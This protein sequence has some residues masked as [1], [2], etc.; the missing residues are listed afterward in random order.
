MTAR[1]LAALHALLHRAT[2]VLAD[3]TRAD[4]A[5]AR[6]VVAELAGRRDAMSERERE[7]LELNADLP[8][9]AFHLDEELRAGDPATTPRALEF[10]RRHVTRLLAEYR[11]RAH[12][13]VDPLD[14]E[15]LLGLARLTRTTYEQRFAERYAAAGYRRPFVDK[16]YRDYA[17]AGLPDSLLLTLAELAVAGEH[18]VVLCVLKGAL[19]YVLLMELCGLAPERV[20]YVMCGRSTGSHIAPE[21]MVAP[22]GFELSELAGRRV[23]V[24]D[25]NAAT[26]STLEFLADALA[27]EPPARATLFLDYTLQPLPALA[28]RFDDVVCGPFP[29]RD[30]D[31]ARALK[32]RLA[33]RLRDN[34]A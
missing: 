34:G 29:A 4:Y 31:R 14:A 21:L 2:A 27:P 3:D 10:M 5:A 20:R 1:E 8:Q 24:V 30:D 33:A 9:L 7:R 6:D 28:A 26:G 11:D 25:N 12:D 19:P 22:L 13:R 15:L 23:L 16:L 17:L 32:R 18:D